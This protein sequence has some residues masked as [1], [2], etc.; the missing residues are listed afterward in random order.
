MEDNEML[1]EIV[2]SIRKTVFLN[3][4]HKDYPVK[5]ISIEVS[6]DIFNLG[7]NEIDKRVRK[8]IIN[9]GWNNCLGFKLHTSEDDGHLML[10]IELD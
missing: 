10:Y 5:D 3:D 1:D 6:S 4:F 7:D 8:A 2:R 9:G